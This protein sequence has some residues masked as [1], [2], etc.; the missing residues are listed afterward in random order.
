MFA[1]QQHLINFNEA[2]RNS[3]ANEQL[4]TIDAKCC[5]NVY[6]LIFCCVHDS[7]FDKATDARRNIG[8]YL[9]I[10]VWFESV[11]FCWCFIST[12]IHFSLVYF[13]I[14]AT[15]AGFFVSIHSSLVMLQCNIFN[16]INSLFT[17]CCTDKDIIIG[18]A[19]RAHLLRRSKDKTIA[20]RRRRRTE[21]EWK[22]KLATLAFSTFQNYLFIAFKHFS[23][24]I[25]LL[26]A[27]I[28]WG[29]IERSTFTLR[30]AHTHSH[31]PTHN[32]LS[33]I[34]YGFSFSLIV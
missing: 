10:L 11:W 12:Y 21:T 31:K 1:T 7:Y 22:A 24:S 25:K 32:T 23:V 34:S 16:S 9:W 4:I 17:V 29:T 19:R 2:K 15:L 13:K 33:R 18:W 8:K 20:K 14:V 6:I 28:K 30:T 3:G 26:L 27:W 5:W